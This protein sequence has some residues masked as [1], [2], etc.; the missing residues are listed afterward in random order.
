VK[1]VAAGETVGYGGSWRAERPS[2]IA[3]VAAGYADGYFRA[4]SF[5]GSADRAKVLV[6]GAYA[7]VVGRVSMDMIT[8]DVTDVPS[9]GIVRGTMVELFGEGITV[10][11]LAR[12]SGSIAY[13]ILTRLGSRYPRL[14]S[15]FDS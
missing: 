3:V 11:D 2:L 1:R 8:V 14:Y 10:D 9:Q 5:P 13:E 6:W 4:C 12:W 15:A 7:P